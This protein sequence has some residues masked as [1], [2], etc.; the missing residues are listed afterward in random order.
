MQAQEAE[1]LRMAR[2]LHDTLGQQIAAVLLGLKAIEGL[3]H[4]R[5]ATLQQLGHL[6]EI[7]QALG[8]ELHEIAVALRPT[9][10]DDAGLVDAL[11][12]YVE[13]W[14][15][16]TGVAVELFSTGIERKGLPPEVEATLYRVAQEALTNVFRHADATQVSVVLE[17]DGSR[18]VAAIEDNGRGFDSS[19]VMDVAQQPGRLGLLGMQERVALVEGTLTIESKPGGGTTI[20]ARIPLARTEGEHGRD[21]DRSRR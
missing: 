5:T 16:R 4:G 7:T 14:S 21:P 20:I 11:R 3:S 9:A 2:E 8:R 17:G 18:V 6:R 19:A 15:R 13:G 10:L 1:R 12:A